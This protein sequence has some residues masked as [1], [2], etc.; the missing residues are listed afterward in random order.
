MTELDGQR[1]LVIGGG[2]GIGA[3]IATRA[4]QEG[5]D[6]VV[7][8]RDPRTIEGAVHLDLTDEA[9]IAAAARI[10]AVDHVVSLGSDPYDATIADLDRDQFVAAFETKVIGPLLVA[11]HFEIRHSMTLFAG[12]VGWRPG[13]GR[14]SRESPTVRSTSPSATSLRTSPPSGSTRSRRES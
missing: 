11:K 2:R 7:G 5:M 4:R 12:V 9:S 10:G 14:S 13:P 3:A 8:A 1:V 6:V